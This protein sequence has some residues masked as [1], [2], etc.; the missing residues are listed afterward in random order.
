VVEDSFTICVKKD[1]VC[2]T[3]VC[4]GPTGLFWVFW[5]SYRVV[6]LQYLF[7]QV[8]LHFVYE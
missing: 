6:H 2:E 3:R 8:G 1:N 7:I 4:G 5:G